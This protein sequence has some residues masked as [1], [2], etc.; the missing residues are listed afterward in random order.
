LLI[1]PALKSEWPKPLV[2]CRVLTVYN[3][4]WFWVMV[5]IAPVWVSLRWAGRR[6]WSP[7]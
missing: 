6:I 5:G 3:R 4:N 1:L 7:R 2:P